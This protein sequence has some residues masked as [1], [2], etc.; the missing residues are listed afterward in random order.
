MNAKAQPLPIQVRKLMV[1]FDIG[2]ISDAA[3]ARGLE[4][5]A[6]FDARLEVVHAIGLAGSHFELLPT[7]IAVASELDPL[8]L[9]REK[10]VGYVGK[11]L[12][13]NKKSQ[14]SAAEI[15]HVA[16]G[17]PATVLVDRARESNADLIVMGAVRKR[18]LFD[19]GSTARG[20][21]AKAPCAVWVQPDIPKPIRTILVAVDFSTESAHALATAID[22][23]RRLGSRVHA[24]HVFDPSPLDLD[25]WYGVGTFGTIE[26]AR[27]ATA[28]AFERQMAGVHWHGVKHD[29]EL[30]SGTPAPQILEQAE[31]ADLLL[32][33][34]HG[35]TGFSA[36]VLG[37]IAY[38]VLVRAP[39]PVMVVRDPARKFAHG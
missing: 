15:L 24:L 28:E 20:V 29:W 36:A 17:R 6:L 11:L 12:E 35:R 30:V 7:P 5:A 31:Q 22:L 16:A 13:Q 8:T 39:G 26:L 27:K 37:N 9:V 18:K 19:F 25:D 14:G 32:M 10:L 1:A 34:T 4:L 38:S 33:G 3:L 2:G 23:G 21:F